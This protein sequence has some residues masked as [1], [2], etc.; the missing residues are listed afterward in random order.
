[1]I[2]KARSQAL[3]DAIQPFAHAAAM[4]W[5]VMD[6]VK[7]ANMRDQGLTKLIAFDAYAGQYTAE[8]HI[9]WSNWRTLLDAWVDLMPADGDKPPVADDLPNSSGAPTDIG[10]IAIDMVIAALSPVQTRLM[11]RLVRKDEFWTYR[12]DTRGVALPTC[13]ALVKRGI[14][15]G[16]AHRPFENGA[17]GFVRLTAFGEAIRN[18]I[19]ERPNG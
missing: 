6:A 9:S 19:M 13:M 16:D 17:L 5:Q 15:E 11:R 14:I 7:Q 3:L 8:S 2:N 1:M 10:A 12:V 4:G 18:I